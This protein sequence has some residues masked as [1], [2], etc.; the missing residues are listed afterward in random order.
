MSRLRRIRSLLSRAVRTR[1]WSTSVQIG[2]SRA[3]QLAIFAVL[4]VALWQRSLT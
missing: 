3:L 2:L 4:L 1:A